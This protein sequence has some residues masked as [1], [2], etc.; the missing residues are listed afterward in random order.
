MGSAEAKMIVMLAKKSSFP[1]G[2][3]KNILRRVD[4]QEKAAA[5]LRRQA[6]KQC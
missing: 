6:E 2:A 4:V 5:K 1:C 3:V